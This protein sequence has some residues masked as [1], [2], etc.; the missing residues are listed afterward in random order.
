MKSAER[1]LCQDCK[2]TLQES[3]LIFKRVPGSE[4][5]AEQCDWCRRYRPGAAYRI[6]YRRDRNDRS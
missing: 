5:S 3:G 6:L 2:K 1:Y 4:G